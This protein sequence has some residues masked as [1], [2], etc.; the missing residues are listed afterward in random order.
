MWQLPL[1]AWAL[2]DRVDFELFFS[3]SL[4]I[5]G[6]QNSSIWQA[7]REYVK[8][9]HFFINIAILEPDG[10]GLTNGPRGLRVETKKKSSNGQYKPQLEA[11]WLA[12]GRLAGC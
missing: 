4:R 10:P 7:S 5:W 9:V 1:G 2:L 3:R 6:P 12:A 11:G 8:N